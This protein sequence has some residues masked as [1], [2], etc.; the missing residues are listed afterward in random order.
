MVIHTVLFSS[1]K[2]ELVLWGTV[3]SQ[4]VVFN[5][6]VQCAIKRTEAQSL[7]SVL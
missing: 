4:S 7:Y 5:F 1:P 2:S 6:W 3:I